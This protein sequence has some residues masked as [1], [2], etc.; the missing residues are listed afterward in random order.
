[1]INDT[2][3]GVN[4]ICWEDADILSGIA[5]Y[6]QDSDI[7]ISFNCN[8]SSVCVDIYCYSM[9]DED[10]M[11]QSDEDLTDEKY[12]VESAVLTPDSNGNFEFECSDNSGGT[13]MYIAVV[14]DESGTSPYDAYFFTACFVD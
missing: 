5:T 6:Q 7:C 13:A 9:I 3:I 12:L 2:S 14:S 10:D 8:A 4:S 11:P 1:M